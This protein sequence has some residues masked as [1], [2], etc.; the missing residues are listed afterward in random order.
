MLKE[1]ENKAIQRKQ[2]QEFMKR[3]AK[4]EQQ[5]KPLK[6]ILYNILI[7]ILKIKQ[8]EAN[9]QK[10]LYATVL[11]SFNPVEG[12]ETTLYYLRL[13]FRG[14]RYYKIGITLHSVAERYTAKD[15]DII[16]KVL[17]EKK[18]TFAKTIEQQIIKHF[19]D[20]VFPLSILSSGD[21]EIFDEDVLKLDT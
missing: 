21:S 4:H 12:G 13:V 5:T 8:D 7:D 16:E 18:L 6:Y 17:Y 19:A 14:K 11:D 20:K 9:R 2:K 10:E 3:L 15:F 1:R